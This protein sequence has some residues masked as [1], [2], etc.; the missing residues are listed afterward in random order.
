MQRRQQDEME[1]LRLKQKHELEQA[2]NRFE[3][4]KAGQLM[5]PEGGMVPPMQYGMSAVSAGGLMMYSGD[6]MA[7]NIQEALNQER[8]RGERERRRAE[9]MQQDHEEEV[10]VSHS[11]QA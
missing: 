5:R 10:R 3:R 11:F 4:E 6:P 8:I 2:E 7:M 1:Q 9:N